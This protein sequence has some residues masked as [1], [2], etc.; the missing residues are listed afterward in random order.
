MGALP[1]VFVLGS[2][3][4]ACSAKVERFPL[5]GESLAARTFTLEAGGKG[6]NLMVGARRLGVAVDGL[7]AVGD[8]FFSGLAIP[9][10]EREGLAASMLRRHAGQTGSGIGFAAPDGEN[11]LA[12]YAGANLLLSADDA[13]GCAASIRGAAM[14]LAQFEIAD[15]PILE[16]FRIAREAGVPTLLNPSP[17]RAPSEELL[18]SATILVMNKVEAEAMAGVRGLSDVADL[19]SSARAL[20]ALGPELV[21]TTLGADGAAAWS[22][23]ETLRQ[24]AFPARSID[25]LGAGDAFTAGLAVLLARGRPLAEALRFAAACGALATEKLGVLAA[26]PT[27]REA[28]ARLEGGGN[29]V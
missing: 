10:L 7:L 12:V 24:P 22:R 9:A 14:V 3:V 19:A 5:P 11:C 6:F 2:F 1:Y 26:L 17:F 21:V 8:D 16:A 13:R 28:H 15:E 18:S 29:K 4:A 27:A 23:G 25:T 20:L